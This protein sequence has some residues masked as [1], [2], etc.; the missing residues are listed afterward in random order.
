MGSVKKGY[1][2]RYKLPESIEHSIVSF[3]GIL[4]YHVVIKKLVAGRIPLYEIF[5]AWPSYMLGIGNPSQKSIR[6]QFPEMCVFWP[7]CLINAR[8]PELGPLVCLVA[9]AGL[10]ILRYFAKRI[11][12]DE[13]CHSFPVD[14]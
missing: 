6:S 2:G 4:P 7:S 10:R 9:M 8:V 5:V 13:P 1:R 14:L 3:V 12:L 11:E